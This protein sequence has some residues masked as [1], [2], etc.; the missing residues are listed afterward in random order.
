VGDDLPAAVLVAPWG[1]H[2]AAGGVDAFLQW[3]RLDP[4]GIMLAAFTGSPNPFIRTPKRAAEKL[5]S[6]KSIYT[7][8]E[9]HARLGPE[10]GWVMMQH[11]PPFWHPPEET[12]TP[13][14]WLAGEIDCTIGVETERKSAAYYG[15][16]FEIISGAAHNIRF[17]WRNRDKIKR[18]K[19][20]EARC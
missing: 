14:L 11:N 8:D 3:W 1:S 9:L 13:L 17:C 19:K 5:L 4:I 6:P 12:K 10:S 16:D 20:G 2:N 15:A 7:P 18:K